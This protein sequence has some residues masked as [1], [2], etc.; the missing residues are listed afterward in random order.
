M[1]SASIPLQKTWTRIAPAGANV[2]VQNLSGRAVVVTTAATLPATLDGVQLGTFDQQAGILV[3]DLYARSDAGGSLLISDGLYSTATGNGATFAPFSAAP[4][5]IVGT[6]QVGQALMAIPGGW[7]GAP[8]GYAYQWRRGTTAIAGATAISYTPVSADLGASLAVSV[9]AS[10][11]SG[12]ATATSAL[13]AAV[14]AAAAATAAPLTITGTPGGATV[15]TAYSFTPTVSGG[16]GARSFTLTGSLPAGLSFGSSTGAITGTPTA[17]GTTSGLNITVA[18]ASGSASLGSF[19]LT[20]ASAAAAASVTPANT[21]VA[22]FGDSRTANY[23]PVPEVTAP[24]GAGYRAT[25]IIGIQ[26]Q[27]TRLSRGRARFPVHLNGGIGG[28]T[29]APTIAASG[30]AAGMTGRIDAFLSSCTASGAGSILIL[31][32]TNDIGGKTRTT[33]GADGTT[34]FSVQN[35]VADLQSCVTKARTAGLVVFIVAELPRGSSDGTGN[36]VTGA[37]LT[38]MQGIRSGVQAMHNPGG[39]VYAID[40]FPAMA[41]NASAFTV[42][43]NYTADGLHPNWQGAWTVAN[44]AWSV[45]SGVMPAAT[46][47]L[48]A[49]DND[50]YN[51]SSNPAGN[52]IANSQM[53]GTGTVADGWALTTAPA[54]VTVTP[55]LVTIGGVQWQQLVLSGTPTG[56][57]PAVTL[58]QT[59]PIANLTPGDVIDTF[60]DYQVDGSATGLRGLILDQRLVFDTTSIE[61]A[62]VGAAAN[63]IDFVPAGG[64][65]GIMRTD[66]WTV[67]TPSSALTSMQPAASLQLIQNQAVSATLRVRAFDMR[68]GRVG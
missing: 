13:T 38:L 58:R 35:A 68:K 45:M 65:S 67:V 18:D 44:A 22:M 53:T 51:A 57:N 19:S 49:N 47:A 54:G 9:T 26:E 29:T 56:S 31:G 55:S 20:V 36:I 25:K 46:I 28:D 7:I 62:Q 16:S 23:S 6:A 52:L 4:P 39:G 61:N 2:V 32:G 10:N 64:L 41:D 21:V 43:P 14:T 8:T 34:A 63:A 3:A 30:G 50:A 42:K 11:A 17:A 15:G 40:A 48:P 27:I 1:A 12:N 37:D 33:A 59:T 66:K 5:T 60:C 24:S